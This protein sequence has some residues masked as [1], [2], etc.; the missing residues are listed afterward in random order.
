VAKKNPRA[1]MLVMPADHY[2][3][4]VE[5]FRRTLAE[6]ARWALSHDDLVTL[7]V[8]PSRPETGY[9]YLRTG[10][11]LDGDCKEVEA[12]VEKPDLHRA[13]EFLKAGNYLWNGGMF[14][15]RAD[16]ILAA[17]DRLMPE[18]K[19]SWEDAHGDV[20]AAYPKMTATSIDYGIME[21]SENVVTFPLDC[22]WDDLGSWTSL[23]S[24]AAALGAQ[25]PEGVVTGGEL[26]AVQSKGNIVDAPGRLVAILGVD[27]LIVVEHGG[28]IL[29]AKKDRAQDIRL[30]V[31]QV[32]KSKPELA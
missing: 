2:I 22:G 31:E 6:A 18:M 1:V 11:A 16:V 13:Q 15:W 20:S 30:V 25:R 26:L 32:K 14:V 3:P 5:K 7:G 12:F 19:K 17:F 24:V 28:A 21:K 9:G 10:K 4:Q 8:S 29:V 23:E 27:D